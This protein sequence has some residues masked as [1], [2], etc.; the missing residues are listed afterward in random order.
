MPR[1]DLAEAVMDGDGIGAERTALAGPRHEPEVLV[2]SNIIGPI[3][4]TPARPLPLG[5]GHTTV[6][7]GAGNM[8]P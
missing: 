3:Y 4:R 2:S 5:R 1:E 7:V 6:S 8:V